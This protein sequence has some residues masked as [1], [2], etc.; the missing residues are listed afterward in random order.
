[1]RRE[2]A[3]VWRKYGDEPLF[4]QRL[5]SLLDCECGSDAAGRREREHAR[6]RDE[7]ASLRAELEAAREEAGH[8][9]AALQRA[10]SLRRGRQV[11][12]W[13]ASQ[14]RSYTHEQGRARTTGEERMR[15][16]MA[17]RRA[18]AELQPRAVDAAVAAK[19]LGVG[20]STVYTLTASGELPQVHIGKAARWLVSDLDALLARKRTGEV[21]S[22]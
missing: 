21:S 2:L 6:A 22:G 4:R 18:E 15:A 8:A 1:M 16:G 11:S 20:R 3:G 13:P 5:R 19:L 12:A 17:M 10:A 14:A 7:I 9:K